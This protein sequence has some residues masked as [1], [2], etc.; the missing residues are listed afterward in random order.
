MA[1]Q[2]LAPLLV[3]T[4]RGPARELLE[5]M[6]SLT[7]TSVAT[8]QETTGAPRD[9]V[10]SR[11]SFTRTRPGTFV[12]RTSLSRAEQ[13]AAS[14]ASEQRELQGVRIIVGDDQVGLEPRFGAQGA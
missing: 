13:A 10:I 7:A 3:E 9:E 1:T 11:L 14:A 5:T 4:L 6:G 8:C 12:V 2:T